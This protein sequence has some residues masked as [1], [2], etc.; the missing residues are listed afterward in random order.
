MRMNRLLSSR[1]FLI[2]AGALAVW[3]ACMLSWA[4]GARSNASGG[5]SPASA[6]RHRLRIENPKPSSRG[7]PAMRGALGEG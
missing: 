6:W 2:A 3:G 4:A 7:H 1:A 5:Y